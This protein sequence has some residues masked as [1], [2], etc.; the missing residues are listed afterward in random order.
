MLLHR[1]TSGGAGSERGREDCP[2][3]AGVPGVSGALAVLGL[4]VLV[5]LL[6]A[7]MTG[8]GVRGCGAEPRQVAHLDGE[9]G[10]V[11]TPSLMLAGASAAVARARDESSTRPAIPQLRPQ[12]AQAARSAARSEGGLVRRVV[13]LPSPGG[14]G[15]YGVPTGYGRTEGGVLAQLAG[16]DAAAF[17]S[18]SGAGAR[19]VIREWAAPGGPTPDTWSVVQSVTGLLMRAGVAPS[20][21]ALLSITATPVLGMVTGSVG[22]GFVVACVDFSVDVTFGGIGRSVYADCE[23]MVW[24]GHGWLIGPG[25]PPVPPGAVFPGS[26]EVFDAGWSTLKVADSIGVPAGGTCRHRGGSAL[27]GGWS[28]SSAAA[29]GRTAVVRAGGVRS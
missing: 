17:R 4:L 14:V 19:A 8:V 6:A 26:D 7:S 24:D 25:R 22:S 10:G 12:A 20:G 21:S 18:A 28:G 9:R 29:F 16:I 15:A 1:P 3:L 2:K 5:G 27:P 11:G 13:V 23:R